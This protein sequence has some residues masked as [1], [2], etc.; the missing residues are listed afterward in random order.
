MAAK[1]WCGCVGRYFVCARMHVLFL[2]NEQ[3]FF[4]I[5][6]NS[7]FLVRSFD[8][9][10]RGQCSNSCIALPYCMQLYIFAFQSDFGL[11][12]APR[13]S[14]AGL[15]WNSPITLLLDWNRIAVP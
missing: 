8:Y 7:V 4:W 6:M 2:L 15:R 11:N 5:C 9:N 14:R 10:F 12:E 3:F 13:G 1:I